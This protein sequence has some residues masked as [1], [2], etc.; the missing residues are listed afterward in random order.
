MI[1]TWITIV[2]SSG[3]EIAKHFA[4]SRDDVSHELIEWL[5]KDII[6]LEAGDTITLREGWSEN[7]E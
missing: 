3:C 2:N 1:G 4:V 6:I 5:R 7:D